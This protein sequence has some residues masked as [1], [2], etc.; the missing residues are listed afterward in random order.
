MVLGSTVQK[1]IFEE[2]LPGV[3]MVVI[4]VKW[5]WQYSQIKVV[6]PKRSPIWNLTS[7][8]LLV[9][10]TLAEQSAPIVGGYLYAVSL[11]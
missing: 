2:F 1:K 10:V 3:D 4:L 11:D 6:S 7:F 5:P 8:G 9:W